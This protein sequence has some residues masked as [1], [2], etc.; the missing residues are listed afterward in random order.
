MLS[1]CRVVGKVQYGFWD[2]VREVYEWLQSCAVSA[3]M[4][5]KTGGC[6][7]GIW[8]IGSFWHCFLV[9]L[10]CSMMGFFQWQC[11]QIH[12][13]GRRQIMRAC[14]SCSEHLP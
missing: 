2:R 1:T 11:D 5:A 8:S 14:V 13:G 3:I 4:L 12:P 10:R 7:D 6:R 9:A